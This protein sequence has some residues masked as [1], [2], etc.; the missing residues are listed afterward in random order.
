[1]RAGASPRRCSSERDTSLRKFSSV[2]LVALALMAA[3]TSGPPPVDNRPYEQQI[4]SWRQTKDDAFRSMSRDSISPLPEAQRASFKGLE[5]FA[6]D[7]SYHV[8]AL[9]TVEQ[10]NPPVII[11]LQTSGVERDKYR[12]VGTLGFTVGAAPYK[13]TAFAE[14]SGSLSRLFVPFGDLT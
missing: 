6:I 11:E 3:C 13:L 7:Q 10:A 8:P 12:K 5:Y 14:E 1:Q 2:G 9:L 4:L